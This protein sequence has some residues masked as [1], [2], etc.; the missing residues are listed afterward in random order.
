MSRKSSPA[1]QK[2]PITHKKKMKKKVRKINPVNNITLKEVLSGQINGKITILESMNL[3]EKNV[4][5]D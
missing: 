5:A 1:P 4:A 3:E 2:M